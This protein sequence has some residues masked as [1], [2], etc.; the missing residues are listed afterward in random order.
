MISTSRSSAGRPPSSRSRL[1]VAAVT[2]NGWPIG[3]HPCDTTVAGLEAASS[4]TPTA[5]S[6]TSRPPITS[7]L[8]PGP[9]AADAKPPMTASPGWSSANPA[10]NSSAGNE[11]GSAS[12]SIES[13]GGGPLRVEPDDPHGVAIGLGAQVE[14]R[15]Q[16][17]EPSRPQHQAGFVLDSLGSAEDR[18]AARSDEGRRSD[19][20]LD[21]RCDLVGR[22]EMFGREEQHGQVGLRPGPLEHLTHHLAD[23]GASV[24]MAR[25]GG[26]EHR[27]SRPA[28]AESGA[29]G[30][31]VRAR[32]GS[33]RRS[34]RTR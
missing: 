10:R 4:S 23:R 7:R 27:Q 21:A 33:G 30:A 15:D 20:G 13:T 29:P 5:P 16:A 12:S 32:C 2:V 18:R 14:G 3:R 28:A 11:N 8:R 9:R 19:Q 34:G 1:S 24:G 31:R 22:R 25:E 26:G 17:G 6:V